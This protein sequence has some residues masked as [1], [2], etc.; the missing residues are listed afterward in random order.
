MLVAS[1]IAGALW[2][3][4]GPAATFAVGAVITAAALA[5]L[6]AVRARRHHI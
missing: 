3:N 5:G 2:D 6:V 4:F 1:V